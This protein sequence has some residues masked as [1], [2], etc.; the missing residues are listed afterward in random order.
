MKDKKQ[1]LIIIL[2]VANLA[3]T[4]FLYSGLK[5]I[6]ENVRNVQDNMYYNLKIITSDINSQLEETLLKDEFRVVYTEEAFSD[7]I[8]QN[9]MIE[10]RITFE[11]TDNIDISDVCV[12]ISKVGSEEEYEKIAA[13]ALGGLK[14]RIFIELDYKENYTYYVIGETEDGEELMLS[15]KHELYLKEKIKGRA[16]MMLNA[17]SLS[18]NKFSGNGLLQINSKYEIEKIE[19]VLIYYEEDM[20]YGTARVADEILRVDITDS[21][22][23]ADDVKMNSGSS[24]EKLEGYRTR[25][26]DFAKEAQGYEGQELYG[27]MLAITFTDGV[28]IEIYE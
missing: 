14:Y 1:I 18:E 10:G 5:K 9:S 24:M 27:L 11:L 26:F 17:L 13:V 19:A 6:D 12:I 22:V 25:G 20:D 23:A 28:E 8:N 3:A 16:M 7:E 2:L 21:L 15:E 4:I